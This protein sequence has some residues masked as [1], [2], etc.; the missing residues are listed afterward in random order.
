MFLHKFFL[1]F[2]IINCHE[3]ESKAVNFF[4]ELFDDLRVGSLDK[5]YLIQKL[6]NSRLKC[7]QGSYFFNGSCYVISNRKYKDRTS[8]L[9]TDNIYDLIKK[10]GQKSKNLI[11]NS[12]VSRDLALSV[13]RMPNEASWRM[14]NQSCA[15]LSND[16]SLIYF[17]NE[18]EYEYL[19]NLLKELNFADSENKPDNI[20]NENE[21]KYYIGLTFISKKYF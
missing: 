21:Q 20:L 19:L 8:Y 15:N 1:I 14:A 6:G 4:N 5:D 18:N 17:N 13:T 16:S 12:L 10:G 2:L 3:Q 7:L 11:S 9:E